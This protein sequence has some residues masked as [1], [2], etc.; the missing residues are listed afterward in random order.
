MKYN[1]KYY[2][3]TDE[4]RQQMCY[5]L[6]SCVPKLVKKSECP[7]EKNNYIDHRL[8]TQSDGECRTICEDTPDC[9]FYFWY[10]IDYSPS[11]LYCY[12]FR[13]SVEIV[14]ELGQIV[15]AIRK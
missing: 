13:R 7:L 5:H 8:F 9:R 12:L 1:C 15:G 4:K 14:L 3:A 11:P 2:N 10:P 6:R